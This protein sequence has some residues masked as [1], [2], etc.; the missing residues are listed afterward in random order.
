MWWRVNGEGLVKKTQV[1]FSVDHYKPDTNTVDQFHV[2]RWHGHASI[3]IL[4]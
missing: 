1:Y 4:G 2:C 3:E